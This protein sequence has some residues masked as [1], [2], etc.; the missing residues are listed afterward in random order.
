MRT[1]QTKT[2]G[3]KSNGAEVPDK[4]ISKIW[5]DQGI[6]FFLHLMPSLQ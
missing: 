5:N 3:E 2:P 4:N 6:F 1:I